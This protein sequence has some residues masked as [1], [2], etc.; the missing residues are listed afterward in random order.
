MEGWIKL[1]R[2]L[3][4]WEW[5]SEPNTFRLFIHCLLKANHKEKKYRGQVVNVGSFLTSRELLSHETGLTERQVRTSLNR[6]KS[7]NELT[8]KS[9]RKGTVIQV[10]KFKEYQ[11]IDQSNDQQA[12]NKRPTNDQQATSNNNDNNDNNEKKNIK[13]FDFSEIKKELLSEMNLMHLSS[14]LEKGVAENGGNFK[15]YPDSISRIRMQ[16]N[17]FISVLKDRDMSFTDVNHIKNYF[18]IFLEKFWNINDAKS[19][20]FK[21]NKQYKKNYYKK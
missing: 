6:L 19:I 13:E 2:R 10:V 3:L 20:N 8:V 11:L 15:M 14:V 9:S 18:K 21:L 1:H 7:T 12:T 5:Y 4:E 17:N 16:Y